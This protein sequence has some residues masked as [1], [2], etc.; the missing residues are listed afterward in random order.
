MDSLVGD[1]DGSCRGF[2]SLLG[3]VSRAEDHMLTTRA[4]S[5]RNI[6][7]CRAI[8]GRLETMHISEMFHQYHKINKAAECSTNSPNTHIS[9]SRLCILMSNEW[10]PLW[11]L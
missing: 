8:Y 4:A 10:L 5:Q 7:H 3:R 2:G 1:T 6:R 11:K 9:Y